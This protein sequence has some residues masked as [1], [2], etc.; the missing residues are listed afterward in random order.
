MQ[1][2]MKNFGPYE[3]E[4]FTDVLYDS[5]AKCLSCDKISSDDSFIY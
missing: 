4:K 3:L 2:S 1:G 5:V